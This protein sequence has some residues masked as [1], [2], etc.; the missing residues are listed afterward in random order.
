MPLYKHGG[1]STVSDNPS[2]FPSC[3]SWDSSSAV[4]QLPQ[5]TEPSMYSKLILNDT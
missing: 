4:G 1:Q 3:G 5:P 2:L